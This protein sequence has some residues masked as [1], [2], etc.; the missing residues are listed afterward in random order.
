MLT[1]SLVYLNELRREAGGT[2]NN[3]DVP[4]IEAL[5]VLIDWA[6]IRTPTTPIME[7]HT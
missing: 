4:T 1:V 3:T 6:R 5:I 7:P 2:I